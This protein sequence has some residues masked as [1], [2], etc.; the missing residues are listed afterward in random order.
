MAKQISGN[1]AIELDKMLL[2][3]DKQAERNALLKN[4][5]IK[6][7]EVALANTNIQRV[8]I[9]FP[10]PT[11]LNESFY[12]RGMRLP[13]KGIKELSFDIDASKHT[14]SEFKIATDEGLILTVE[15]RYIPVTGGN[16]P[17]NNFV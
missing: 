7:S 2:P 10:A 16:I 14:V 3:G 15:I 13:Q 8:E 6:V 1:L 9:T 5:D 12:A 17:R 4:A 11:D